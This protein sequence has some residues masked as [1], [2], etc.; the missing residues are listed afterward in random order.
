[1]SILIV[2]S[3]SSVIDLPRICQHSSKVYGVSSRKAIGLENYVHI[4]I[5]WGNFSLPSLKIDLKSIQTLV[6]A[7]G[8]WLPGRLKKFSHEKFNE[9]YNSNCKSCYEILKQL[10]KLNLLHENCTIKILSSESVTKLDSSAPE[11]SLSKVLGETL[12]KEFC[13]AHNILV[14]CKRFGF[15]E[16]SSMLRAFENRYGIIESK[17]SIDDVTFFILNKEK[18]NSAE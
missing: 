15:I 7:N 3:S 6:F 12:I 18:G 8:K 1:M 17:C 11:Y 5:D 10:V 14:E 13:N 16:G 4:N 2:G 9:L